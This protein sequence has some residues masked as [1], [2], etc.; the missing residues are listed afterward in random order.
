MTLEEA[1]SLGGCSVYDGMTRRSLL[2]EFMGFLST[3]GSLGTG[4]TSS[5]G[6]RPVLMQDQD[7]E[8]HFTRTQAIDRLGAVGVQVFCSGLRANASAVEDRLQA[9]L[10]DTLEVNYPQRLFRAVAK[11][12]KR[13]DEDTLN[14]EETVHRT[15]LT[16]F[17]IVDDSA[18]WVEDRA[19]K[20]YPKSVQFVN[21]KEE[22]TTVYKLKCWLQIWLV[23]PYLCL[24]NSHHH[25]Y[26]RYL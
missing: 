5:Q 16:I 20:S 22:K 13:E 1:M 14:G 17:K 4:S 9:F 18:D 23:E 10:K 6:N 8:N 24:L 11:G 12:K 15:F 19:S 21:A 2:E 25:I 3:R 7:F 26:S